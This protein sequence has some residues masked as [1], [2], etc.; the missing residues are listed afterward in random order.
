[1]NATA[2]RSAGVGK[3]SGARQHLALEP[4]EPRLLLSVTV[5]SEDF[6]SGSMATNGWTVG[7]SNALGTPAYWNAKTSAFGGEAPH[8][9]GWKGY[10]AGT[11]YGGDTSN[12]TYQNDMTAYMYRTIDLTNYVAATLTYWH[13]MPST[14]A[15]VDVGR[16]YIDSTVVGSR[17][18]TQTTW[19]LQTVDLDVFLGGTHTLKFEFTSNSSTTAEGWYLDDILVTGEEDPDDAI[20]EATGLGAVGSSPISVTG[21]SIS[22]GIDVDMYSFTVAAGQRVAFD[23]DRPPSGGLYDSY[24]RLF[25][26]TGNQLASN[27]N[28]YGPAPEDNNLESYLE[29]TFATPGT[30]YIGVSGQTNQGYNPLTGGGDTVDGVG[31]YDLTLYDMGPDPS[32]TIGLATN[33]GT[34]H[35][36][37]SA[38]HTGESIGP[39]TDVDMYAFTVVGTQRLG[40]DTDRQS[41]WAPNTY[42]RLFDAAGTQLASNDDGSGFD[43]EGG[44]GSGESYLEHWFSAAGTYYIGVSGAP[45]SGYNPLTGTGDVNGDV[46]WYDLTVRD[47][48]R[49]VGQIP[50]G[51]GA[52]VD[53]YDC[54]HT[55]DVA[56]ADVVVVPGTGNAISS[57]TLVG[58]QK[59]GL[60][61]A[62]S[63]ASSV[64]KVSDKRSLP[65]DMAFFVSDAPV[66]SLALLSKINGFNFNGLAVGGIGF[67]Q[68]IDSDG[69]TTDRTALY[70][71]GTLSKLSLTGDLNGDAIVQ[72]DLASAKITGSIHADVRVTGSIPKPSVSVGW[73]GAIVANLLGSPKIGATLSGSITVSGVDSKG[74]SIGKLSAGAIGNLVVNVTGGVSSIKAAGWE[75]GSLRA[76]WMSSLSLAGECGAD[77]TLLGAPGFTTL[78]KA[79]IVGK[80]EDAQWSVQ[81]VASSVTVSMWGAGS[82]LAVGVDPG[83]DGNYFT[84]DDTALAG[85]SLGKL[86]I[87]DHHNAH[88]HDFG[89]LASLFG[90]IKLDAIV[91]AMP[92]A[93]NQFRIVQVV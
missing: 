26:A 83:A 29:Y 48:G 1:M 64:G 27:D 82:C 69:D 49:Y 42:L 30:Y 76:A 90:S 46:G 44:I 3:S 21:Q 81:G 92:F 79:S 78:G 6:E 32:D 15:S 77:V 24:L 74:A 53:V 43:P 88:D 28:Q 70:V 93:D 66:A 39:A 10:C 80:L 73:S 7:D 51:G 40:F 36:G 84:S 56:L 54:D 58:A 41:V 12:P 71:G 20:S 91:P 25:N 31:A 52:V 60:G 75:D 22:A 72:G 45:N 14:E 23:V 34:I 9:G 57:I 4:L 19:T 13:L 87:T 63:G 16:A 59:T 61:I 2:T 47:I 62:I 33:L 65:G 17:S 67:G 89:I 85:S 50:A 55:Y 11:G 38:S 86:T 5:L 35:V 68:D 8:G 37:D 18:I